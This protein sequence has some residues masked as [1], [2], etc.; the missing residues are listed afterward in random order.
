LEPS[1]CSE[2]DLQSHDVLIAMRGEL[3]KQQP[4]YLAPLLG[5]VEDSTFEHLKTL[6]T[7]EFEKSKGARQVQATEIENA[8]MA[9]TRE[10]YGLIKMENGS[11]VI[12]MTTTE[13]EDAH[14]ALIND[15]R[16]V[17][18]ASFKV[19]P[20][21]QRMTVEA[22]FDAAKRDQCGAIYSSRSALSEAITSLRREN[23]PVSVVPLWFE[24]QIVADRTD[25]I[26]LANEKLAQQD[27]DRKK[28]LELRK[29]QEQDNS[30][31]KGALEAKLQAQHGPQARARAEEIANAIKL[32]T[33][34]DETWANEKFPWLANWY[35]GRIAEGWEFVAL[36]H[37]ITDF[38]TADW[39]SRQLEVVFA[40]F[41]IAM[42]HRVLGVHET[43]CF[44]LGLIFDAEFQM[45]REPFV[46]NCQDAAKP[47]R[48]W[49][50]AQGFMGQWIVE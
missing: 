29:Q 27:Q 33:N 4:S 38:G 16:K 39:K 23:V 18:L 14:R 42:K 41:S 20:E 10:G 46:E 2:T 12:C 48:A 30:E 47:S 50:Q 32:L 19:A 6:T 44:S 35:R 13:Q 28:E 40:E 49:K 34:D 24:P 11:S 8:I 3:L 37:K 21:L 36:N 9:G 31:R 15:Q 7:E 5:L 22:A 25:K 17:V 45:Y 43:P 26:R 1:A